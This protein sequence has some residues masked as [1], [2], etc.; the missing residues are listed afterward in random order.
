MKLEALWLSTSPSLARFD[1]RLLQQLSKAYRLGWWE[2]AQPL[3]APCCLDAVVASLHNFLEGTTRPLHLISHGMGGVA[4]WAYAC[5]YPWRVKSLTLL[6]LGP[7]PVVTWHA[8]Y[9]ALRRLLPCGRDMVLA[10]MARLLFGPQSPSMTAA[11]VDRLRLDLDNALTLQSLAHQGDLSLGDVTS[12]LL[13]CHGAH[14]VI[15]DP[16]RQAQESRGLKT[17]DR[18]WICPGGRHFFHY[19]YPQLVADIIQAHW[20]NGAVSPS[21]PVMAQARPRQLPR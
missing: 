21:Q 4:A 6:S 19:D 14:D 10:Q 16:N 17:G 1:Q 8:H 9:Y 11:L 5:R 3:D 20:L 2:Y 15:V 13:V 12:P 7:N 18:H